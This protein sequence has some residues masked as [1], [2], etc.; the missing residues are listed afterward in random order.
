MQLNTL[1]QEPELIKYDKNGNNMIKY[2]DYSTNLINK[3]YL[4]DRSENDGESSTEGT[5]DTLYDVPYARKRLN[6]INQEINSKKRTMLRYLNKID[7]FTSTKRR[8]ARFSQNLGDTD[9]DYKDEN[10][11]ENTIHSKNTEN[12]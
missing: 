2:D 1:L 12:S 5:E 8:K 10:M 11:T 6:F 4:A 3:N 7:G 9:M